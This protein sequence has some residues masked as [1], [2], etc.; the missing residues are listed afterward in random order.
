MADTVNKDWKIVSEIIDQLKNQDQPEYT[1]VK[2]SDLQIISNLAKNGLFTK[3][4]YFDET[5]SNLFPQSEV[6]ELSKED[7]LS[8]FEDCKFALSKLSTVI[9]INSRRMRLE[10]MLRHEIQCCTCD[11]HC[12]TN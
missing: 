4:R 1:L 9:N 7:L 6:D 10:E 12:P 2:T 3:Y 8:F 5:M 11:E